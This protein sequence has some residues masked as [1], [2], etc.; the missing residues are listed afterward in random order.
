[1]I[2]CFFF[3]DE[4]QFCIFLSFPLFQLAD[5]RSAFSEYITLAEHQFTS[6]KTKLPGKSELIL[7]LSNWRFTRDLSQAYASKSVSVK[8]KPSNCTVSFKISSSDFGR[9]GK[10]HSAE[11]FD[12][13]RNG[14]ILPYPVFSILLQ[15]ADNQLK[16]F[17]EAVKSR[18][19][20]DTRCVLA[21]D[22]ADV[23]S[24][25]KSTAPNYVTVE[26]EVYSGGQLEDEEDEEDEEDRNVVPSRTKGGSGSGKKGAPSGGIGEKPAGGKKSRRE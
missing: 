3:F 7:V 8:C 1:M 25:Q 5:E 20:A 21:D 22:A 9:G 4:Q 19:D 23:S 24:P 2:Y 15:Q 18:Y 26:D 17:F 12:F 6:A 13:D 10:Q 14:A 11:S 16:P